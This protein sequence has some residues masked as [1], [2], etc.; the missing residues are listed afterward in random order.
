MA[1]PNP[2]GE[3]PRIAPGELPKFARL[4]A[5]RIS[6]ETALDLARRCG[7][8]RFYFPRPAAV[9]ETHRLARAVGVGLAKELCGLFQGEEWAIPC[10]RAQLRR[11]D[12]ARMRRAGRSTAE[13]SAELGVTERHVRWLLRSGAAR[14]SRSRPGMAERGQPLQEGAR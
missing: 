12:A 8:Q 4:V 1:L 9:S 3:F 7:G 10:C 11:V 6:L 2:R 13:I 14:R 5:R